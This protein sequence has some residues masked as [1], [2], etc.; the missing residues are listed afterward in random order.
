MSRAGAEG[1]LPNNVLARAACWWRRRRHQWQAH[2]VARHCQM[3]PRCVRLCTKLGWAR[4]ACSSERRCTWSARTAGRAGRPCSSLLLISGCDGAGCHLAPASTAKP[5]CPTACSYLADMITE[6]C[7][8]AIM[9]AGMARTRRTGTPA[10]RA[11]RR[12][13]PNA[14]LS[15][16]CG[17]HLAIKQL[18]CR[19]AQWRPCADGHHTAAQAERMSHAP[20][21][22][23]HT[24][25]PARMPPMRATPC[26]LASMHCCPLWRTCAHIKASCSLRRSSFCRLNMSLQAG[27]S[28]GRQ[29]RRS[30]THRLACH[31]MAGPRMHNGPLPWPPSH[32]APHRSKPL[33]RSTPSQC[34]PGRML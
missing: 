3:A 30:S 16:C 10:R 23:A 32:A 8:R 1:I 4:G 24:P 9:N 12:Q 31:A 29:P 6:E 21:A 20:R 26:P 14:T 5:G 33:P 11:V 19:P 27:A 17:L 22:R 34:R 7:C 2:P 28:N 18:T 13:T 25:C 15:A